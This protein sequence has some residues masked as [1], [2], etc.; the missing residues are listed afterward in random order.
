VVQ[1]AD[2]PPLQ[3]VTLGLHPVLAKLLLVSHPA[4][5]RRLSCPELKVACNGTGKQ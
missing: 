1:I 2:I 5:D 4:E 3:S